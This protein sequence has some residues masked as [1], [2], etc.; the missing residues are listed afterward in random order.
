[1]TTGGLLLTLKVASGSGFSASKSNL[2]TLVPKQ[3]R[4][5]LVGDL[6]DLV[7]VLNHLA[8]LVAYTAR[9]SLHQSIAG[10]VFGA[11]IAVDAGPTPITLA[12]ATRA[13]RSIP[14]T[15]KRA[16]HSGER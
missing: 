6:A 14:A 12:S 4:D 2:R 1:M 3:A 16:T 13:H 5:L 10:F 11:D 7:V 15:S 9:A 8:V